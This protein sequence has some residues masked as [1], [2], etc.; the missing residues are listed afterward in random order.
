MRSTEINPI[1]P[2][3][4]PDPSVVLIDDTFFLLN[5]TFHVF[6]GLP[7]YASKNL[8]SWRH[9]GNAINRPEQ[10]SLAR[11]S[12]RIWPRDDAQDDTGDCMLATGGLYAPTIRH[13]QGTTYIVCTNVIHPDDSSD[14]TENF[15]VSTKDIWLSE[16]SDPVYFEFDGIDPSIFFDD[17]G[18]SYLQGSAGPGPMTKIHLFEIDLETGEKK[19][20]EKTIWR[21]TGGIYSEGPHLYKKDGFYY[22][23]ISEGGTHENHMVTVARSEEIWGPYEG[24]EKNPILTARG[25]GEYIRYTGHSDM[26]Q[27]QQGQWWGVCLGVRRGSLKNSGYIMGRES[28]L[29]PAEWPRGEWPALS[30]VKLNPVLKDGTALVRVEGT[31]RLTSAPM[32]DFLYIRDPVLKDH[33]FS[34]DGASITLTASEEDI[35]QWAAPVTFVGKRQRKLEGSAI[36]AMQGVSSSPKA[37]LKA[38]LVYYKDEHRYVRIFYDFSASEIV[39][40]LVNKA[41]VI[42]E[43]EREKLALGPDSMVS[44]RISYSETQLTLLYSCDVNGDTVWKVLGSLPTIHMSG[45]D[46]VGPLIGI[47]AISPESGVQVRFDELQVDVAGSEFPRAISSNSSRG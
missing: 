10:L 8:T 22:L 15:I 31:S 37:A 42:A 36:V 17:D 40:E 43:I 7:I 2:G 16:W 1:I 24:F 12:T 6:P 13:R 14:I 18:R 35:S 33:V 46:F 39:Y 47:F 34:N 29:T 45:P 9:I 19:S 28:F 23:V 32:V 4:S 3:F 38:G 30:Q 5:S 44:L 21:G 26:F 11:S 20:E 41:K 25:T 27:D